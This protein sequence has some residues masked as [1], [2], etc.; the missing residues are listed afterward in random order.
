SAEKKL[1]GMMEQLTSAEERLERRERELERI[2]TEGGGRAED[3]EANSTIEKLIR[4][5]HD[6]EARL[7]KVTEENLRLSVSGPTFATKAMPAG[8]AALREQINAL[9]AEFLHLTALLE[10]Q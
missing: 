4:E 1:A 6:L 2:R 10:G 5:R 3:A 8:D 9:A 7:R